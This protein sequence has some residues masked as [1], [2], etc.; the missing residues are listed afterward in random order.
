MQL[1]LEA[2]N[3]IVACPN[4]RNALTLTEVQSVQCADCQESYRRLPH[5]WE[6][7]PSSWPSSS[8]LWPVWEQLQAN[9]VVSYTQAPERNLGVGERKDCF[10]FSRF[11]G[12]DG[13]VL[14]VGCGPQTWPTYFKFHTPGTR[15]VGVDP[16]VGET[17]SQYV[18]L[19]ALAE[20]LPFRGGVFDH[21]VFA[22]SLDHFI[23]PLPALKEARRVCRDGGA[24]DL[25]I[26]EKS[27]YSP[28][29]ATSPQWYLDLKKPRKAEDLFHLK[30]LGASDVRV[31]TKQVGLRVVSEEV[32]VVDE[33][34]K[35]YFFKLRVVTQP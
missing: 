16:L 17:P 26:G 14:D 8:H 22:T 13:L 21:V 4:C 5:S 12:F 35:N 3:K 28:Q 1:S 2:L 24:I 32:Q 9:G 11:C 20:Y 10:N 29:L 27:S 31:L 25:W 7:I 15:F 30:R 33:H 19:R 18:Q 34:R 6:L 23:D